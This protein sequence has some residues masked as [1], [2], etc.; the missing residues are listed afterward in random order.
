MR[1]CPEAIFG[2]HGAADRDGNCPWCGMRIE[3][4]ARMPRLN[5][6]VESEQSHWY[7]TFYDPDYGNGLL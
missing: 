2:Q 3:P 1:D 5:P 6:T 4:R 7:R